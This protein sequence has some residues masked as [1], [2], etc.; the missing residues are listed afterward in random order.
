MLM[1]LRKRAL[2]NGKNGSKA[3]ARLATSCKEILRMVSTRAISVFATFQGS[4]SAMYLLPIRARFIASFSASRNLYVS[5]K[6]SRRLLTS[7]NSCRVCTSISCKVP[8]G[9][10]TPFQYFF[11]SC[12]AR[13]TKLPYT[14]TNSLLLRS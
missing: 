10:T 3:I 1:S 13:F 6:L 7:L 12:K 8:Q 11:V 5:N 9:G 2:L 4:Q 14:P